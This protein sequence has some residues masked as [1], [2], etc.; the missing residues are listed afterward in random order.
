MNM[1]RAVS[2]C[3]VYEP[4]LSVRLDPALPSVGGLQSHLLR[5]RRE[6]T[7]EGWA[8]QGEP[9]LGPPRVG[10]RFSWVLHRADGTEERDGLEV[11]EL[12]AASLPLVGGIAAQAPMR[13]HPRR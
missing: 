3:E 4:F 2:D 11:V 1:R 9:G 13:R 10:D 7:A 12:G 8:V 6:R 5:E